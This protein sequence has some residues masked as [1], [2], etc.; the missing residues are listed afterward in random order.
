MV[1]ES[2]TSEGRRALRTRKTDSKE[3][4]AYLVCGSLAFLANTRSSLLTGKN[5]YERLSLTFLLDYPYPGLQTPR[6]Y[7]QDLW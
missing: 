3:L 5:K 7:H 6:Q 2:G 1:L 4:H